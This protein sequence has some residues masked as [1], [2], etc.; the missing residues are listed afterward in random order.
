VIELVTVHMLDGRA[1]QVNVQE[2]TQLV[3]STG[4]GNKSFVPG[5]HCVVRLTDGTFVSVVETCET[6]EKAMK[7]EKP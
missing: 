5:I 7:G 1:V 4:K 6:I 3:H 2:V